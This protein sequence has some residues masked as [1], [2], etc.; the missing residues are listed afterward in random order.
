MKTLCVIPCGSAKIWDNQPDAGPVKAE[1]TYTGSF[2]AK[3]RDY[4]RKYH[5]D[6]V[7]LSAKHGY[8]LPGDIVPEN[9]N[10]TFNSKKTGPISMQRLQEQVREKKLDRFDRVI[11]IAGKKYAQI[12]KQSFTGSQEF[13]CP[14]SHCKGMGY[15]MQHLDRAIKEGYPL[16]KQVVIR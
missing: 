15:M 12:V 14:L 6:W 16:D 7:I 11:I 13:I 4:A 10:I 3:C 9:Y 5:K 2:H 1:H 8:L